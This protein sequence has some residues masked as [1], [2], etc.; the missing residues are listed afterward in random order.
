MLVYVALEGEYEA[1][2]PLGVFGSLEA[3]KK[4]V[5][6]SKPSYNTEVAVFDTI[7]GQHQNTIRYMIDGG[8][9]T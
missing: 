9:E 8:W 4:C 2:M 1:Y 6:N 7:S 3:A 5:D